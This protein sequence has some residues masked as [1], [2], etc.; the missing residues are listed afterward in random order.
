MRFLC[1]L[2][3]FFRIFLIFRVDFGTG[4]PKKFKKGSNSTKN[5]QNLVFFGPKLEKWSSFFRNF[6]EN[7]KKIRKKSEKI[8][9]FFGFLPKTS[10]NPGKVQKFPRTF[11]PRK[12]ATLN[13]SAILGFWHF[14]KK[15]FRNTGVHQDFPAKKSAKS[16]EIF[17]DFCRKRRKILEKSGKERPLFQFWA[18]KNQVLDIFSAI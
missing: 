8:Q 13:F 6:G 7:P 14:L 9:K 12:K 17:R 4:F 15:K 11:G 1:H 18:K 3:F 2:I 10:K 16:P 5:V